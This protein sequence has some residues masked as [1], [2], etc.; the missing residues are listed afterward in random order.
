M[1]QACSRCGHIGARTAAHLLFSAVDGTG[2]AT[3]GPDGPKGVR[4]FVCLRS[5]SCVRSCVC[6]LVC[7]F[8]LMFS[9]AAHFLGSVPFSPA[10]AGLSGFTAK[11]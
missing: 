1:R 10:R 8:A 4:S 2:P 6:V 3:D 9:T 5:R 11:Y 7:L